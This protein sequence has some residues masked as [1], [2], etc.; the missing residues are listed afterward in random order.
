M[1]YKPSSGGMWD[2]TLLYFKS[3]YYML[4][5]YMNPENKKWNGM[6]EAISEDGVHF[7]DIGSALSEDISV[8]K[9]FAY[10]CGDK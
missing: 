1:F 9:M 7:K 6:W 10:I 2:P 4:S 8:C 5:M 3:R